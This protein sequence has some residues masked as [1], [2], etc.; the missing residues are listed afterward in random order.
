M[1]RHD[2]HSPVTLPAFF[3]DIAAR[4]PD[5]VALEIPAGKDRPQAQALTYAELDDQSDRI[6]LHLAPRLGG[7]GIVALLLPRT[8]P[9]LYVAQLAVLKAGGAFTCLDPSFPDERMQ[10]ILDDAAPVAVLTLG[11]DAD[12]LARLAPG[13]VFD[14][15]TLLATQ[16]P[17][18]AA[19][20]ADIS[21]DRLA[22]V[23]YTSG[24][25]G[26]PKGVIIEHRNIANLVASDVAEFGLTPEDRVVQG[27]SSAYDSS[28]EE[29][30]LAFA[31]GATLL[32][33]DDAA[34]RLGPDIVA[35]L[36]DNGATVFCPPPTLLRSSGCSDPEHALPDLK[37]LYVGGEAL[38]RDIADAWSRGRRM[39]NGYGPTEC[40]VT[41][42]RGDIAEGTPI[43]IGQPVPGM[44]AWV[45]NDA[46]EVVPDGEKGELC[47]GGE[48]LARGYRNRPDLTEAQF[49]VHP[50]LG[51]IYRTG[52]LV[53]READGNFFYH[54]R[55]DAQVKIRGY[56]VE[57]GEIEARLVTLPGVR[58][59]GARMQDNAGV[60]EL[61]AFVVPTDTAS[62]PA[63]DTLRNALSATL[64]HYMVPRQ[65]AL[66]D[67]LPTS[68]GGKL[69]RAALPDLTLAPSGQQRPMVSPSGDLETLL[70][71]SAADILKRPAGVSVEDDFFEDLGGDSLTAA[72][73]VTLLREDKRSDWITVSDIYEART[74]RALASRAPAV[75]SSDEAAVTPITF[76]REGRYR[77]VLANLVQIGWLCSELVIGS[78]LAWAVA[79]R[80]LPPV[81]ETLGLGAFLLLAPI[82]AL[83]G[84][85]LYLPATVLFAVA[86]KRL[87]IGRYRP[88]RAPVWSAYYLRHWVVV[89][90]ARLVPWQLLAGT[91]LQQAILRALGAKIGQRVHI[92][93]GVELGRGGWDLL[94]IGD[95]VSIGQDAHL[96]LVELDRGDIVVAPVVLEDDATLMVRAGVE[97]HCRVGRGAVLAALSVLNAGQSIPP[98]ELWDGVPARKAGVATAAPALT[99][100]AP[101]MGVWAHG[102]LTLLAEGLATT[103]AALPA[104]LAAL[105]ACIAAGLRFADLWH[106][107]YHPTLDGRTIAVVLGTTVASVPLTL[108]WSAL[109]MRAMGRVQPGVIGRWSPAYIRVWT[110]A[111]MV[112][113]AGQWLSGT[114]FWSKWLRLAG[115]RVGD[116]CEISTIFDVT[117]ELVEIGS[118]TFFADGIYLGGPVVS[119]GT[120]RLASM[121]LGSNT[122]L[123]NHAVI[124]AGEVLPDDILVGIATV[125][126]AR[127]IASGQSRFGH[128][129][130]DLPRRQVVEADRSLT[131]DPSAI[132]YW[133]RV[134][135]EVLRFALPIVP[136]MLSVAWYTILVDEAASVSPLTYAL[137]V[138]PGATLMPLVTLCLAVAVLKWVLI[139][140]VKPGQHALWSCWCSRWDFVYVAWQRYARLLLQHLE[141]TFLLMAYLRLMGLKIGRRAVLGPHFAQV[142]DPDMI[143]VGDGATVNALF[144]AHTFE[145]RVLKVGP[146][147]I[148]KGATI[149]ARTVPLYGAVIGENAHVGA[150]SVI[151]KHE[152]LRPGLSYQGVPVRVVDAA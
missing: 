98:G 132:R 135:W 24:T 140:R 124:P 5:R 95:N 41:C 35:W 133:N 125:A 51:R 65:I 87:V 118:E 134:F 58:A 116:K 68:V 61:V 97:G 46:M 77:P 74:I 52:D 13:P 131:H 101:E 49:I 145:D 146:V 37:L 70:A 147:R 60:P 144:Q 80:L 50:L 102:L 2:P 152:H 104:E 22:Y 148:G 109:L 111:G 89:Q 91:V 100:A 55:I 96:G 25:T 44:K 141:G 64:P 18:D 86:V 45:L 105:G 14:A 71:A 73:L 120:V 20:P 113:A 108:V 136:M 151:M 78:W 29:T 47:M 72:M 82:F 11:A 26:R 4:A 139:G 84:F 40:A 3:A 28:I 127:E 43:T 31:S 93:R 39:V 110:K 88:V 83:A 8:S 94:D 85:A 17:A 122:F 66:I 107:M 126:D 90:A 103:L 138:I 30:W 128:P 75:I 81:F 42:L 57:L 129:S 10:E 9:L 54:G 16:P 15:G 112:F 32:V 99:V 121:A 143:E 27:S 21:G 123:G 92:H 36:R 137:L 12:R 59:A 34:A 63:S 150:H 1:A 114:L 130:F 23:I 7:E 19:L 76:A 6:A 69:N 62:P 79:F 56:R 53:H 67:A 117:P 48:G 119:R 38:P 33:M 106:W 142:V 115:M 149:A